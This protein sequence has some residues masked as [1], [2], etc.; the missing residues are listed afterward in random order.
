MIA[1]FDE[2]PRVTIRAKHIN[3]GVGL[4]LGLAMLGEK[5]L[6]G[7]ICCEDGEL[8]LAEVDGFTIDYRYDVEKD[9]WVDA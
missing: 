1:L 4:L 8:T 3:S 6:V 5:S 9:T 2:P 7:I